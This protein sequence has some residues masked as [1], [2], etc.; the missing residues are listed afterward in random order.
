MSFQELP[1]YRKEYIVN[2]AK[3]MTPRRSG[4]TTLTVSAGRIYDCESMR[5]HLP[6]AMFNIDSTVNPE[7]RELFVPFGEFTFVGFRYEKI[8]S[9]ESKEHAQP[10]EGVSF[11]IC[12]AK[13]ANDDKTNCLTCPGFDFKTTKEVAFSYFLSSSPVLSGYFYTSYIFLMNSTSSLLSLLFF[14]HN[15]ILCRVIN[16]IG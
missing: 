6:D 5:R 10:A 2:L 15:L 13:T 7:A 14:D 4:D 3:G 12:Q 8:L 16:Y 9:C 1:V 11:C